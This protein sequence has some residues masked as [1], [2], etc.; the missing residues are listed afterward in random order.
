M[1]TRRQNMLETIRGGRPDRFVNQFEALAFTGGN[2]YESLNRRIQI[3]GEF[4]NPWGVTIRYQEN[5]PGPFP[6]HDE[7]H[8][9]LKDVARWREFVRAPALDFTE[10]EWAPFKAYVDTLDR[11]EVFVT[12]TVAPGLFE[13]LHYLMGMGE[14][15]ANFYLEPESM[16]EL[17][18]Y[19]TEWE[20]EYAAM[21][22]RHI[23]PDAIIHHNDWGSQRS[24]FLSPAMFEEFLLPSYKRIYSFYKANGVELIVHHS[25]SYAATLVPYMIEMGVDVWQGCLDTNNVPE[26][27]RQYGGRIS[28]MGAINNGVVDVPDWSGEHIAAYVEKTCRECGT[29]YFIPCCTAGGPSST[30]PGVYE[31][32]S[33]EIDRMS[34]EMFA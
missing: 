30:Y 19:I 4:V 7:E 15:L 22:C 5:T 29:L 32:V 23:R 17:I 12:P 8:K 13:H 2:P 31:T 21:L 28:F 20:L 14:C 26:L 16:K 11:S 9:V 6:V 10:E 27:I 33:R 3:G 25:D 18:E 1:L 24:T 34:R